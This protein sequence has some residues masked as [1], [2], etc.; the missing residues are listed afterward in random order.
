MELNL[1]QVRDYKIIIA[2]EEPTEVPEK[3]IVLVVEE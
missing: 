2:T 3:T 1:G